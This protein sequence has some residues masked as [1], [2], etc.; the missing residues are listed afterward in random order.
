MIVKRGSR[1]D[2]FAGQHEEMARKTENYFAALSA[3]QRFFWP[4]ASRRAAA[5]TWRFFGA[6]AFGV[7]L[8]LRPVFSVLRALP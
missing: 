1:V 6:A 3:A 4:R 2:G 5:L 7:W 8:R